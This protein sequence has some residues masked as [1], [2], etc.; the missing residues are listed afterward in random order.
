VVVMLYLHRGEDTAGRIVEGE[1]AKWRNE[2]ATPPAGFPLLFALQIEY[3]RVYA[4]TLNPIW[5]PRKVV[6]WG[7]SEI[8]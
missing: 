1:N 5:G 8:R 7:S 4:T 6:S 2:L 3:R